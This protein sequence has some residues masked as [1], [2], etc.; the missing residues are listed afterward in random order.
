VS[1]DETARKTAIP[2][3][4]VP[5]PGR[6][7][8]AALAEL[9]VDQ[10]R[11]LAERIPD[12]EPEVW[13]LLEKDRRVGVR[14]LA[15]QRR[16]RARQ[17]EAE[18]ARHERMLHFERRFWGQ[19]LV[20]IAGVD[21][22]GRGCLAG[23]VVAAAVILPR[24]AK[25]PGLD[26][27]KKLSC[28]KREQLLDEIYARAEAVAIG[29][30]EAAEIDR[31]NILQAS[32]KAMRLALERLTVEPERV[33]IDGSQ[34]PGS[35]FQEVAVVDGDARSLS[36]AAASVV[37]KVCRDRQMI[38]CDARYPEYG[39]AAHK[40]YGSAA[41]L[42]ALAAHG[43]CPLHRRSFGPVAAQMGGGPS[44]LF[45][46]FR[47]GLEQCRSRP[48][49]DSL[50]RFIREGAQELATG[51][52][53]QLRQLFRRRLRAVAG[54]GPR[55]EEVAAEF[56]RRQGYSVLE[57]GYRG[58][59]GE[60][61]LV[62]RRGEELAFVEVKTS[63]RKGAGTPEERVDATKRENLV[64]AARHYLL[65]HKGEMACRFDVVTVV[66]T[67]GEPEI[68]HLEDAFRP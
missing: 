28:R 67:G 34:K 39:F 22:A 64:R 4:L 26:D 38:D 12:D 13:N 11:R 40:G 27:S 10:I 36:I 47:E 41:H 14:R 63:R 62:V 48:E 58:A 37:A 57:R 59:G 16:R 53:E 7:T 60:I 30:V 45:L 20:R 46:S 19:G 61:D 54:T 2:G 50:G 17:Q 1:I 42:A 25:I 9:T 65:R 66:L 56:L 5:L 23:P 55:G 49:L 51:E 3:P 8:A 18:R 21:E 43:P 31:V 29:Q 33:L 15:V 24:E 6:L 68:D 35:P 52:L 32:L 44:P